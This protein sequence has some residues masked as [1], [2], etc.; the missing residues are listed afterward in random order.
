MKKRLMGALV[1]VPALLAAVL[2]GDSSSAG[3][4]YGLVNCTGQCS[5]FID[6]S[7][8]GICDLSQSTATTTSS[9]SD[10]TSSNDQTGQD[11]TDVSN[12]GDNGTGNA[13]ATND[14]GHGSDNGYHL[15]DGGEYYILPVSIL[16]IS[17]YL[18]THYLFKKGILN[19][20][21]HR[22]IWN[23]LLAAGYLGTSGTG[24]LLILMINL[25]IRTALNP[26]ITFWHV[27]LSIL[28]VI[29]TLIHIHIYR[30]PFKN[31]FKVLFGFKSP[32]N[33]KKD[34]MVLRTSK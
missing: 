15:G 26:S 4:P 24:V 6:I 10:S 17:G 33:K 8:D 14:P 16:L 23:L 13:S 25:G 31:M 22:K 29:G 9:T 2:S 32:I 1:S 7:G 19:R 20:K 28:M 5:R 12:A 3:C 18:F 34:K 21:K 30:K 27:E 11:G